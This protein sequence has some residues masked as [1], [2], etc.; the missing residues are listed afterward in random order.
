MCG[1]EDKRRVLDEEVHRRRGPSGHA[2]H[3]GEAR[4]PA[5][6]LDRVGERRGGG[7]HAERPDAEDHRGEDREALGRIGP[8]EDEHRG[9]QHRRAADPDQSHRDEHRHE[10]LRRG[11]KERSG[12]RRKHRAGEGAPRSEA[13]ERPADRELR[14]GERPEPHAREGAELGRSKPKLLRQV[15][16][17]D[18]QERAVELAQHIGREQ[19]DERDHGVAQ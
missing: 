16:R 14:E 3:R 17:Y 12:N 11:E 1:A 5:E 19:R 10:A 4:A 9:H 15:R 7:E 8:A 18:R 6:G 2:P 13:V